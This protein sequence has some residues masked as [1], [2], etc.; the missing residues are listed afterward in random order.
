MKSAGLIVLPSARRQRSSA[1]A[2][3]TE[4]SERRTI[5]W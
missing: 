2:A 1:S 5:G 4:P 3:A